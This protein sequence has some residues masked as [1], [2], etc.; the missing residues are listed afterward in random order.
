MID[1]ELATTI[2]AIVSVVAW[3]LPLIALKIILKPNK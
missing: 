3:V 2:I 1:E